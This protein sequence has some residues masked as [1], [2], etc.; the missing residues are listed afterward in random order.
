[1]Y[2]YYYWVSSQFLS[3]LG[4]PVA[5]S[6]LL[7]VLFH[8]LLLLFKLTCH[9]HLHLLPVKIYRRVYTIVCYMHSLWDMLCIIQYT[10]GECELYAF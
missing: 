3:L 7:Q 8:S 6:S 5:T 1:M 9:A 10:H 4:F 2:V